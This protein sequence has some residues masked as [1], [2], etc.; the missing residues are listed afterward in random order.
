[1]VLQEFI[2]IC[3]ALETEAVSTNP[4]FS[5]FNTQAGTTQD[6]FSSDEVCNAVQTS[7]TVPVLVTPLDAAGRVVDAEPLLSSQP[8]PNVSN[9]IEPN[10]RPLEDL[11]RCRARISSSQVTGPAPTAGSQSTIIPSPLRNDNLQVIWISGS[12]HMISGSAHMII[13]GAWFRS[14]H[15][16]ALPR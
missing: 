5:K 3:E 13:D 4:S 14:G 16:T 9:Q 7:A 1:M 6:V 12:A 2:D 15:D 11:W 10:D 8:E